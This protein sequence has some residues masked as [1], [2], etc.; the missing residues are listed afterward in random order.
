[1]QLEALVGLSAAIGSNSSR[2]AKI[3]LIAGLLRSAS[4]E[5]ARLGASYLAGVLPQGRIGVGWAALRDA[6]AAPAATASLT[7]VDVDAIVRAALSHSGRGSEQHRRDLL[8]GL[9]ERATYEEQKFLANLLLGE[10]HHGAL[11]GVVADGVAVAALVP[12]EDVRRALMVGVGLGDV[13][14]AALAG[15]SG[16][17]RRF[18]L[19]LFRPI[20]PMLAQSA[21]NPGAALEKTGPAAVEHKYDGARIQVHRKGGRVAVFTR[22]LQDVTDRMPEVASAALRGHAKSLILDGEALVLGRDGRPRPFQETAGRF[23]TSVAATTATLTPVFFDL[24]YLNGQD[25]TGLPES[26]RHHL[27]VEALPSDALVPRVEVSDPANAADVLKEALDAGQEGIVVKALDA[28]YRAGRRGGAWV[29]VKPIHTLDLV[30]LAAEWGHGRRHGLLSNLHLGAR[31]P[32]GGGFVMLGKTFKGLTDEMLRWQT[33]RLLD[34]ESDRDRSVVNV[35]PE[36]VVEIAFDGVQSSPRYPGGV[37]LRF[38]RVR[39]YR[40]DKIASDADTI[41]TVRA[42]QRGEIRPSVG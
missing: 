4:A 31:D 38:A 11:E 33:A 3:D 23:G 5:D 30:V 34:L 20:Q 41:E 32:E 1:M 39:G 15:G 16:R 42:I 26:E 27:L 10:V 19:K 2:R 24:L 7:L 6:D 18:R 36:Q 37:A 28:I 14:A 9:L 12:A 40:D 13:A 8:R 17:L 35:R 29:K 21:P 22:G 25:L